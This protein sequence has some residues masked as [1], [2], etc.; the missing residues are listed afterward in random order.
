MSIQ[1]SFLGLA[2]GGNARG[3][4]GIAQAPIGDIAPTYE[5]THTTPSN[6]I[7]AK[8]PLL[9]HKTTG[10][11]RFKATLS[12]S[13][14]FIVFCFVL[15]AAVLFSCGGG[16]GGDDS[17]EPAP[18][19][20]G[21]PGGGQLVEAHGTT[22]E[23]HTFTYNT[24]DDAAGQTAYSFSVPDGFSVSAQAIVVAGGGGGGGTATN[25]ITDTGGGGG[26]GGVVSASYP[27][28]GTVSVL[29]GK[30]G[31][32]GAGGVQDPSNRVGATGNDSVFDAL[33]AKGGGG[34]GSNIAGSNSGLT[35]GSSGGGGT[36]TGSG[37]TSPTPYDDQGGGVGS[38]GYQG[39]AGAGTNVDRDCG[40][41]GGGAG[42]NG[43]AGTGTT[44]AQPGIGGLPRVFSNIPSY[45]PSLSV[46]PG[47]AGG[48]VLS[49]ALTE[50]DAA[51][52]LSDYGSGGGGG[53]GSTNGASVTA[54]TS[55]GSAGKE[56]IVI[57]W[58]EYKAP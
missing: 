6:R 24:A 25:H 46:S 2:G 10:S 16:G 55:S 51:Q 32:G 38:Q 15:A 19:A 30:G 47:G 31:A 41:G 44:S 54:T 29:V 39:G 57:V 53:T 13:S 35:G 42:G 12:I 5:E 11:G 8:W 4:A 34:G 22:Y 52:T 23:V 21:S 3:A 28:S 33:T 1:T 7:I 43:T 37:G 9:G 45:S 40:G 14:I 56:G 26:G 48:Y 50:S 58:W 27:I 49:T 17:A 20:I 36:G 18:V